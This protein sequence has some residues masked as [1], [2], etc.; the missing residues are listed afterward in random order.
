MLDLDLGRERSDQAQLYQS[1]LVLDR[2]FYSGSPSEML[3]FTF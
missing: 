3:E 1:F 2:E